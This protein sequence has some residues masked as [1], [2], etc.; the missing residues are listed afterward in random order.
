MVDAA[1]LSG[2][3]IWV[4]RPVQQAGELCRLIE[5][6]KGAPLVL[7]TLV[8]RPVRED[9]CSETNRQ[10]LARAG[11]IIFISKNAVV[12]AC[13]LFPDLV[14][15][16]RHKTVLAVGQATARC[17]SAQGFGQVG[18]VGSGGSDALLQLPVLAGDRV[19]GQRVVIVRGRD[20]REN[21]R[22]GLLARGAEVGYLEVYRREKPAISQAEMNKFWHDQ[23]P[24]VVIIT[25]LAGLENLVALTPDEQGDRLLETG[26]VVMSERIRQQ[27]TQSGFRRVAV[28][29][30][31]TDA[32]LVNALLNIDESRSE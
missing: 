19:R 2:K 24:D 6:N 5:Q 18:Q 9:V 8:I 27:A 30:D 3:T 1:K 12:H 25:S 4:T 31:N 28:A 32:G 16:M 26:L 23:R 17:L 11:I 21:L 20:G 22:A 14:D 29:T 10:R 13:D 15:M 7:P